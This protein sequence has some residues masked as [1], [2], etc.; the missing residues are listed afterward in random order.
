MLARTALLTFLAIAHLLVLGCAKRSTETPQDQ[1]TPGE[2]PAMSAP[3]SADWP[4]PFGPRHDS[5]SAETGLKHD[6]PDSGPPVLWE[7]PCGLGYSI[8]VVSDGR[9]IL[10]ERVD[11]REILTALDA[12]TGEL[13][14][15]HAYPATYV[16]EFEAY[17]DGPYATPVI[18][19]DALFALGA[20]GTF[21]CLDFQTGELRWQRQLADEYKSE[22]NA[23]G[24]GSSP[25]VIGD[26]VIVCVGG[27]VTGPN[28]HG[29]GIVSLDRT[30]GQ[31]RWTA[32]NYGDS[33]A[34]PKVATMHGRDFLFVLTEKAFVV[35]DPANGTVLDDVPYEVRGAR[36]RVTA[37]SPVFGPDGETVMITGGPGP[38]TILF[39]VSAEGKLTEV[40]K[41]HRILDSQ[42]N[43]LTVV[44][45]VVFGFTSGWTQKIF[46]CVDYKTGELLWEWDS[47]LRNGTSIYADGHLYLLGEAGRLACLKFNRAEPQVVSMTSDPLLKSPTYTAPALSKHRLYLRNESRIICCDLSNEKR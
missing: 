38:G 3:V 27:T 24:M 26:Q 28:G 35:L 31:T 15:E 41:D 17:S 30:T 22:P 9:L 29:T 10:F 25:L 23:F 39:R 1:T 11:D 19:G 43:N 42:F 44:D 16:K 47:D 14:W 46:R 5:T 21:R 8:P 20:A 12:A 2:P 36:E 13:Q 18:D 37:V 7:R 33:Y 40:W 32:T 34:T 6:W 45:Y 4:T